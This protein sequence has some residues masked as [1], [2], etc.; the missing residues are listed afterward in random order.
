[1]DPNGRTCP[2]HIYVVF[3]VFSAPVAAS[4][5]SQ[6]YRPPPDIRPA[7]A[8]GILPEH[9]VIPGAP[10]HSKSAYFNNTIFRVTLKS[11]EAIR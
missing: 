2:N 7:A 1:M 6:L 5:T 10:A 8:G 4:E 9:R 11:P 3:A